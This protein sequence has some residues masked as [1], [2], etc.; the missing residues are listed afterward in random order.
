MQN[1]IVDYIATITEERQ[2]RAENLLTDT[3]WFTLAGLFW[4]QEGENRFGTAP[5]NE[6]VFPVGTAPEIAGYFYHAA[7]QTEVRV[8]PG[9]AVTANGA[10][11]T[12][13]PL[14]SDVS[15]KPDYLYLGNLIM[16]LLQRGD[17][18]AIRLFDKEHAARR[19]FRGLQWYPVE[20]EYRI[21]AE[22]VPYALPK[23][24]PIVEVTGH[25]YEAASPG[26][27][28]FTWQGQEFHLD[29]QTRGDRLFYNFRDGTNGDTTY[30]AGRFLYSDAPH[31]GMVVLDFNLAT[32]PFCAYTPYAT[33]PLPPPD[34]RLPFRIEAGEKI[35]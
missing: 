26:R 29:A 23:M 31:N 11:V 6:I 35:Y 17:R 34:N 9:V 19:D 7:G 4:L 27:A 3:G 10:E 13:L 25:A 16:L 12:V 21:T 5:S 1:D 22:F 30:G 33:C 8:A 24:L 20:L 18:Y 15:G 32:N 14:Q 2:A 28:R